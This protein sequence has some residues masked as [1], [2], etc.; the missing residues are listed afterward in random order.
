MTTNAMSKPDETAEVRSEL[1]PFLI[2]FFLVRGPGYNCMGYLDGEGKWREAIHNGILPGPVRLM[3]ELPDR[4]GNVA[5]QAKIPARR[6]HRRKRVQFM[7]PA[8]AR[9]RQTRF[10]VA[11]CGAILI[12]SAVVKLMFLNNA[13]DLE[14]KAKVSRSQPSSTPDVNLKIVEEKQS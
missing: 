11:F 9:Q 7:S 13:P 6:Q 2:E 4:T 8:A 1:S 12:L 14:F 10:L 3:E 5:D